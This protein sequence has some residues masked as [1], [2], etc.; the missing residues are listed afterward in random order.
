MGRGHD[1]PAE[2]SNTTKH[3]GQEEH[4]TTNEGRGKNS[5]VRLPQDKNN[6]DNNNNKNKS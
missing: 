4:P 2:V 3:E 5:A 1:F 6:K